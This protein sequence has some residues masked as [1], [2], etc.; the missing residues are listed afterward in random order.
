MKLYQNALAST[1]P[2]AVVSLLYMIGKHL[3]IQ[4]VPSKQTEIL[5]QVNVMFYLPKGHPYCLQLLLQNS[6]VS[7]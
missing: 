3:Y 4:K 5:S 7:I 6:L 2:L 1:M